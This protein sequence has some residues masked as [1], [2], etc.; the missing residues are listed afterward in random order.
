MNLK[1]YYELVR[2]FDV[3]VVELDQDVGKQF[4]DE[5]RCKYPGRYAPGAGSWNTV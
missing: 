5:S 1:I 4:I 2:Y 3:E